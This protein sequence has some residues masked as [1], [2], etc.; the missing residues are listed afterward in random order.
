MGVSVQM[1]DQVISLFKIIL[2]NLLLYSYLFSTGYSER[3]LKEHDGLSKS[4][5]FNIIF[6][7]YLIPLPPLPEQRAIVSKIEQL[8]SD[9][10]NGIENFKKAQAQLKLY[11]Q[12]VLKAACEGKLVPTEAELARA[13]GR[14]Y[15][16]ADVLLARILK[17]RREKW[18]GKGKYKEAERRIHQICIIARRLV[19][20]T[21][22]EEFAD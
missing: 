10:D 16:A 11:R 14:D 8:F 5:N 18:N 6:R 20:G 4:I 21:S 3:C 15:E 19:M 17:E 7:K 2:W 22:F 9:L 1:Q 13:E 12:S